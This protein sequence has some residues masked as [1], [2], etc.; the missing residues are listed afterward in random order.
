MPTVVVFSSIKDYLLNP[1]DYI[2]VPLDSWVGSALGWL[3]SNFRVVFLAMRLPVHRL[4]VD[5]EWLLLSVPAPVML[6]ALLLFCWQ[7]AGLRSAIYVLI[8]M[9]CLGLIGVWKESMTTL[10]LVLAAM[11]ISTVA[12]IPLGILSA[13]SD[14]FERIITPILDAMQTTPSFVYLVPIVMLFGIGDVSGV[15][16]TVIYAVPPLIRLTSLGIRQVDPKVIEA[17]NAFGASPGQ[18]LFKI[19]L[20]LAMRTIMAGVNQ[21]L[22]MAL[23]MVVVASMISVAGLGQ[24]VLRG[25]SSLNMG[26]AVVGGLGIVLMAVTIDRFTQAIGSRAREKTRRRWYQ[27]GPVGLVYAAW[28]SVPRSGVPKPVM[29]CEEEG[30]ARGADHPESANVE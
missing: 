4:L 10:S 30:R 28:R 14:V 8:A 3:V 16:V 25:I 19:Q 1:F 7:L 26:V 5:V 24:M 6:L 23:A 2:T 11:L 9:I 29:N 20:P 15:I 17:A 13:R 27:N 21:T 12:G 18:I 22:M